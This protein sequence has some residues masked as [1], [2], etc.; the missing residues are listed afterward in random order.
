MASTTIL[1]L[2]LLK[3]IAIANR[4]KF[5]NLYQLL[6]ELSGLA[7]GKINNDFLKSLWLQ[8]LPA[9][10]GAILQASNA[11]LP[12]LAKL[13]DKILKVSDFHQM[14][15]IRTEQHHDN[16]TDLRRQ[17]I[18]KQVSQLINTRRGRY[19]NRSRNRNKSH[20]MT[21]EI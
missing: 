2:L 4:K 1:N 19:R 18:E 12:E 17:R 6:N 7:K 3:G 8:R 10:T 14:A 9:H 15:S 21:I 5:R 13:A 16:E 11:D 20:Y